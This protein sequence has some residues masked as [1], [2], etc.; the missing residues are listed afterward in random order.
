MSLLSTYSKSDNMEKKLPPAGSHVA[1]VYQVIDL[2]THE[3]EWE[4]VKRD[5]GLVRLSF[6][7]C[8]EK[9]VFDEEKGE[10]PFSVH[11]RNLTNSMHEKSKLR[12]LVEG[13]TGALKEE[14]ANG[15]DLSSLIGL[16][17]L[18]NIELNEYKGNKYANIKSTAPV[19]KGMEVP[20]LVNTPLVFDVDTYSQEDLE[21]LPSFLQDK[22]KESKEVKEKELD[23]K[24]TP[25]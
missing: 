3:S 6:E 4:G 21:K 9:V 20:K 5:R 18:V 17:C 24:D 19:P 14:E 23:I 10:Q 7:L 22:V 16:D 8:N 11:T 13:I 15:F 25:F 12:P 1:R 2:G